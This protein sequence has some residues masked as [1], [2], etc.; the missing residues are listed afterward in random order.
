MSHIIIHY[1][2]TQDGKPYQVSQ[3]DLPH[4]QATFNRAMCWTQGGDTPVRNVEIYLRERT[5]PKSNSAGHVYDDG[6][7]LEHAIVVNYEGAG[8]RRFVMGAIQRQVGAA[9]EFHS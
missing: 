5:K 2:E 4:F 7:W 8:N 9:S 3:D 6:G 1:P